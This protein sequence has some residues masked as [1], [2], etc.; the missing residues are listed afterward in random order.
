MGSHLE[1]CFM[2]GLPLVVY[3]PTQEASTTGNMGNL[4]QNVHLRIESKGEEFANLR[5]PL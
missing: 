3:R 2:M 1:Y 4:G 5:A